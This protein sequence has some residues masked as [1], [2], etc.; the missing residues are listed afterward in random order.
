VIDPA[1]RRVA[2]LVAACYFMEMLDG[3]IVVTALP[4]IGDAFDVATS[5]AGVLISAYFITLAVLIPA[6]GW[7]TARFGGRAVLL[8]AIAVFTAASLGCAAS[9][10]FL[11][12]VAFRVL[13]GAGAALMVPV[14]RILV[15]READKRHIMRLMAYVVW[16]GLIAPVVAPLVGGV[17]ATYASW[18]WLFLINLPL[19]AVAFIVAWRIVHA[20]PSG[21]PGPFDMLGAA[22]TCG[23]LAALAYAAQRA[24]DDQPPWVLVGVTGGAAFVL[25][26]A[27]VG[28]LLRADAPLLDLRILRTHTFGASV[29]GLALFIPVVVAIP[30][31]LPLL[32]QTVFGWS[33]VKS[34]AVVLFV[35]VGNIAIKPATTWLYRR[36]GFRTVIASS[37]AVL[38]LST[39]LLAAIDAFTPVAVVAVL[40]VIGGVARS[41][42]F[43]GY[44]TL[45]LADVP[46]QAMN[47]ASTLVTTAQQLLFGLGVAIAALLLRLGEAV[48]DTRLAAFRVAFICVSGLAFLAAISASRLARTSGAALTAAD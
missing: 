41:I 38:G 35:F 40:L 3:T 1:L 43:T 18:H 17:L 2:L 26:A 44:N 46:P 15:F 25:L 23:G 27:A 22:L 9:T 32:F 34:G 29:T 37:T 45:A 47:N 36:G 39:L 42:G 7:L 24:T 12:L 6:S 10:S 8:T 5:S 21:D 14:G 30:F 20:G 28:H 11:A 33:A 48:A 13:Q 19:G 31:L 4:Q 16:P